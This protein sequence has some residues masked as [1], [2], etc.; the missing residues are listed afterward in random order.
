VLSLEAIL[1]PEG[2]EA[3]LQALAAA[4]NVRR[5]RTSLIKVGCSLH[6]ADRE[7][8][9]QQPPVSLGAMITGASGLLSASRNRGGCSFL[10]C[11]FGVGMRGICALAGG[12]GP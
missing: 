6:V 12:G 5:V 7:C 9:R 2:Q 8:V 4:G 3:N 1:S 11:G 10:T